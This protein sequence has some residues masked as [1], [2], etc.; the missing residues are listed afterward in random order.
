MN[1]NL[2]QRD[3]LKP[4]DPTADA[5]MLLRRIGFA[6]L[7]LA[8]PIAALVSR[9]AAVVLV[10]VAVSLLLLA[11]FIEAPGKLMRDLR[12][13]IVSKAG[14]GL[15][16]LAG[17]ILLSLSWTQNA[18]T[19]AEKAG[20]IVLAV[21]LGMA[22][23]AALPERMRA[24]NLNLVALGAG[25]AALFAHG[26]LGMHLINPKAMASIFGEA[27]S[28]TRG[29]GVLIIV[30]WP[31][32]AWLLSRGRTVSALVLATFVALLAFSSVTEGGVVAVVSG[33]LTFG[34]VTANRAVGIRAIAALTAGLLLLAPLIPFVLMP[35]TEV[36]A[37]V[38]LEGL[39]ASLTVW[40]DIVRA[41]PVKL[42]TGHGLDTVLR[43][44]SGGLLPAATPV[45][46]LFETWYE[47]GLVG[48]VAG[49][50]SLWFAITGAGRMQGPLAAGGVAAYATA[51]ALTAL[52]FATLQSWWLMT[53]AAVA[54]LF[55]AVVRGQYRTER[56]KA[57]RI[58]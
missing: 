47:L 37:M 43:G 41:E 17:W 26:L 10:P 45:S 55:T 32:L 50:G 57:P 51:F 54:L 30:V 56:P 8:L 14:L 42:I 48:A 19:A 2:M 9:R 24:A 38:G 28:I 15:V 27:G 58:G 13:V 3:H 31:A 46:I 22:G 16:F 12:G 33:A 49:A 34:L 21:I 20:N 39:S 25:I 53:L 52:G 29:L 35:F 11:A 23:A 40:M 4:L 1:E 44:R 36:F 7:A 5:A 18:T 6:T